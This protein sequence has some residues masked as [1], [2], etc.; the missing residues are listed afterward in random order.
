MVISV[1]IPA[2]ATLTDASP[3]QG[4]CSQ[5]NGTVNCDVGDISAGQFSTVEVE[6]SFASGGTMTITAD[7]YADIV[8]GVID[9]NEDSLDFS[10]LLGGDE[11]DGPLAFAGNDSAV[12]IGEVATLSAKDSMG[13]TALISSY[14]WRQTGG[15]SVSI[16]N[17]YSEEASFVV[18]NTAS[19][20][21][22][23]LTVTDSEGL[24]STDSITLTPNFAPSANAG[25]DQQVNR[26]ATVTLSASNSSDSDGS[27]ASYR[28][29]QV[30]GLNTVTILNAN[31]SRATF[32]APNGDDLITINLTV[33]DNS[34]LTSTDTI[35]ITVGNGIT[36]SNSL[37]AA[38]DGGEGGG[39][40]G[41][42][43]YLLIL[44]AILLGTRKQTNTGKRI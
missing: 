12:A 24:S 43:H 5:S 4:F 21:T 10:V 36:S 18:P 20:L 39:G 28:W 44:M 32:S 7:T 14:R 23:E 26:S 30:S 27:I 37:N 38:S 11:G 17:A 2:G 42:L 13:T 29:E 16:S 40:G 25:S 19:A 6:F 41:S 33:T 8:E 34:G 9:N 31:S 35:S 15:T 22:F 3:D 1:P